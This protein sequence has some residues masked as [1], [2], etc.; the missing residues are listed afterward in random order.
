MR[1]GGARAGGRRRVRGTAQ[2]GAIAR[3]VRGR[4]GRCR[5]RSRLARGAATRRAHRRGA[6]LSVCLHACTC[7]EQR[8][9]KRAKPPPRHAALVTHRRQSLCIHGMTERA[10]APKMEAQQVNGKVV[11]APVATP[12]PPTC[13]ESLPAA[14]GHA[15]TLTVGTTPNV[16]PPTNMSPQAEILWSAKSS[17]C[18]GQSQSSLALIDDGRVL[19]FKTKRRQNCCSIC[20]FLSSVRRHH[21]QI[22]VEKITRM[23]AEYGQEAPA[24]LLVLASLFAVVGVVL[25]CLAPMEIFFLGIGMPLL[26]LAGVSCMMYYCNLHT[27]MMATF[28]SGDPKE[29][30]QHE[31]A[32][33]AGFKQRVVPLIRVQF[34]K[35]MSE[36]EFEHSPAMA[37]IAAVRA[38]RARWHTS[39]SVP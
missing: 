26:V 20:G 37:A 32:I 19:E 39:G 18:S 21:V 15:R 24:F 22:P 8:S 7:S 14:N 35:A 30:F 38:A 1:G 10:S 11:L 16:V 23:E 25:M 28:Y 33:G 13:V 36:E 2:P 31:G 27:D 17:S 29:T 12:Q 3:Q 5:T 6:T 9:L 34:F 4:T